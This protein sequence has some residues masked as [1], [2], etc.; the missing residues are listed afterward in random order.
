MIL[1]VFAHQDDEL[2]AAHSIRTLG[3]AACAYLTDGAARVPAARRN[4]ESLAALAELG[5]PA[6]RVA[7][8][9]AASDGRLV[10]QLDAALMALE[11]RFGSLPVSRVGLLAWEGGHPDHDAAH[12]VGLA[13]AQRHGVEA[14]E[15]P[16]YSGEGRVP[17][18]VLTPVGDGWTPQ[19]VGLW[20]ALKILSLIRH[21]RSQWRTW[22]GLLPEGFVRLFLFG[23][24][25]VRVAKAARLFAAPHR[26]RLL[27][28]RRFHVSHLRFLSVAEPFRDRHF[29]R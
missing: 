5:V 24:T 20:E 26:G 23:R 27:Y 25:H 21:Y 13:F 29:R 15:H 9:A 22:L 7:F 28:E 1:Y 14:F 6:E 11:E 2:A 18:R 17:F 10:E 16:L 8:L 12:L 4:A 19:R 3:D